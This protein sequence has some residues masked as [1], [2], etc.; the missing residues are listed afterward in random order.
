[1]GKSPQK[2]SVGLIVMYVPEVNHVEANNGAKVVPAIITR[3]LSNEKFENDE[4]NLKVFSDGP[5][6]TW[7]KHI[8]Y[9]EDKTPCSWHWPE[10]V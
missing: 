7:R 1:M 6:D 5:V 4:I 3:T 9:S 8:P 10:R 2:P